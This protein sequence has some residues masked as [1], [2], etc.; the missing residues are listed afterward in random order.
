MVLGLNSKDLRIPKPKPDYNLR[1]NMQISTGGQHLVPIG[2]AEVDGL[3][4]TRF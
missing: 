2:Q 1:K 3:A 4:P